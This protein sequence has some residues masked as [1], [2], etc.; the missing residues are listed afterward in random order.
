MTIVV[1]NQTSNNLN[2]VASRLIA[3]AY[4]QTNVGSIG[5]NE[6]ITFSLN[7]G[8]FLQ[9][10]SIFGLCSNPMLVSGFRCVNI[11][12]VNGLLVVSPVQECCDVSPRP[13]CRVRKCRRVRQCCC[14][15]SCR[16]YIKCVNHCPVKCVK[17]KCV[18]LQRCENLRCVC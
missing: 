8:D 15:R 3:G 12:Y 9:A 11:N 2:L 7:G 10:C 14:L 6:R 16:C 1:F 18:R 13:C 5:H 17:I 4:V